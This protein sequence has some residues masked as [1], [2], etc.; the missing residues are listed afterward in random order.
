[1]KSVGVQ[2]TDEINIHLRLVVGRVPG[3]G[4][5]RAKLF[6]QTQILGKWHVAATSRNYFMWLLWQEGF[7][8]MC[9]VDLQ[10]TS[11]ASD[12]FGLGPS[13]LIGR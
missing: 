2:V 1:M 6:T 5:G 10:H 4:S 7:A 11:F 9:V 12:A 13:R 8:E 3:A